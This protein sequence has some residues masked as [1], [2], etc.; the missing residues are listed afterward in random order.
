[1]SVLG[2]LNQSKFIKGPAQVLIVAYPT[3]GYTGAS[4]AAKVT[5]LKGLFYSDATTDA[6]RVLTASPYSNISAKG[7]EVE[8]KQA[9]QEYDP[10][11]G[12]KYKVGNQPSEGSVSW[13][14]ADIDANKLMDVFS[15]LTA[16][17]F[18]TVA[19]SGVAGRKTVML[20][21]QNAPLYVA[22]CVRFA[23]GT[24]SP[25]GVSEFRNIYV[26]FGV[27]E[28]SDVKLTIDKKG[29][30]VLKIKVT[31]ICDMTLQGSQAMPP[32]MLTDDITGAATS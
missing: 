17:V 19:G 13:E 2:T 25:T 6:C 31:A 7:V 27:I 18:T 24:V 32:V 30:S 23:D 20:G 22:L 10:N 16:D 11:M 3:G 21:R 15:A 29:P 8:L 14:F 1:M 12:G 26:P 28:G 4:D 9:A 5:Q